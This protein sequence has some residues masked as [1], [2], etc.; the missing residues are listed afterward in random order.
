MLDVEGVGTSRSCVGSTPGAIIWRHT[1]RKG[2]QNWHCKVDVNSCSS[3]PWGQVALQMPCWLGWAPP[4]LWDDWVDVCSLAQPWS[5]IRIYCPYTRS[6]TEGSKH[7][8]FMLFMRGLYL[9]SLTLTCGNSVQERW[10]SLGSSA[11]PHLAV[12]SAQLTARAWEICPV[13]FPTWMPVTSCGASH[14]EY[15]LHNCQWNYPKLRHELN[16]CS[17][18]SFAWTWKAFVSTVI[19]S[20]LYYGSFVLRR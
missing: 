17:V 1:L 18:K 10:I 2:W 20:P 7:F 6:W 8:W 3:C 16:R 11:G 14:L 19:S 15:V 12:Y 9:W 5:V 4:G 13:R